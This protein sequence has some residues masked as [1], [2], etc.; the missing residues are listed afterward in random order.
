[1]KT[2]KKF[3]I[4][5]IMLC[6]TSLLFAQRVEEIKNSEVEGFYLN[7]SDFQT[8]K[9]TRPT[10]MLHDGD[11]I[12]LKQFF[13]SPDIISIEQDAETLFYKDSIFAIRLMNGESFRFIYSSPCLIA[14]TT[15]LYIYTDKR[16]KIETNRDGGNQR[17]K[18]VLVTY[19]FFSY[20]SHKSVLPLTLDNLRKFVLTDNSMH[21]TIC[22]IFTNDEM[23]TE[24]NPNTGNFKLNDLLSNR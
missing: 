11:K 24:I 22:D 12:K 20:G 23:L 7:L 14:D 13:I 1:M 17:R 8:S 5:A 21:K 3:T 4:I 15:Y 16:T 18:E 9:L 2:N 19:Y 10:D 6:F